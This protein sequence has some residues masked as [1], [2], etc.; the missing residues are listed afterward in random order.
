MIAGLSLSNT[1]AG[2]A[3]DA[4]VHRWDWPFIDRMLT[5]VNAAL[6]EKVGA[7][8]FRD[9]NARALIYEYNKDS[10][11]KPPGPHPYARMNGATEHIHAQC[12]PTQGWYDLFPPGL[13]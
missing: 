12:A 7:I 4:S 1:H 13:H 3:G 5:K 11:I 9:G 10:R 6:A 8:S 2:R